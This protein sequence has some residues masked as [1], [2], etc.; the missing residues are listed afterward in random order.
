MSVNPTS[1]VC[2]ECEVWEGRDSDVQGFLTEL[3]LLLDDATRGLSAG[4]TENAFLIALSS[5]RGVAKWLGEV[6]EGFEFSA[7]HAKGCLSELG[8]L[9]ARV[10][11]GPGIKVPG[12]H[13][14]PVTTGDKFE[15]EAG[16]PAP[17][18]RDVSAQTEAATPV[19]AKVGVTSWDTANVGVQ[20]SRVPGEPRKRGR[21]RGR[22]RS[23]AQMSTSATPSPNSEG[24]GTGGGDM[25]A[26]GPLKVGGGEQG[27]KRGVRATATPSPPVSRQSFA[28]VAASAGESRPPPFGAATAGGACGRGVG[29]VRAPADGGVM[30]VGPS[31]SLPPPRPEPK[32][33]VGCRRR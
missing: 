12:S 21:K 3:D 23:D 25:A 14:S 5:L 31:S 27:N 22:R 18:R 24:K 30:R 11:R 9:M 10:K 16:L 7:P 15:L 13:A 8:R 26:A 2:K 4:L 28:A 33:K 32:R 1:M 6:A 29:K 19:C 17:A 20:T